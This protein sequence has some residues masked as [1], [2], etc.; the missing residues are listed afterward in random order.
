VCLV[1]VPYLA[2]PCPVNC[3]G[4]MVASPRAGQVDTCATGQ[5][6]PV[7]VGSMFAGDYLPLST[8][9]PAAPSMLGAGA[10]CTVTVAF[11]PTVGGPDPG[12]MTVTYSAYGNSKTITLTGT[13]TTPLTVSPPALSCGSVDVGMKGGSQTITLQNNQSKPVIFSSFV[14]AGDFSVEVVGTTCS[15]AVALP[16]NTSCAITIAMTPM[17]GGA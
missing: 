6:V 13:G 9:C 11:H 15:T 12:T 2:C 14:T 1:V 16:A 4:V 5:T 3:G 17:V 8:T 7:T 10:N